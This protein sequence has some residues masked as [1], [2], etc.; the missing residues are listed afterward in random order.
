MTSTAICGSDLHLYHGLMPCLPEG[1]ILGH[2]FM[3]SV[4][5]VGKGVRR[6][7]KGDRILVP[8]PVAC[9]GVRR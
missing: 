8:F 2:E 7:R 9:G 5:D 4:E 6:W 1:T 3:G